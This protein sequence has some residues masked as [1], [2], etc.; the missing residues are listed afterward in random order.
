MPNIVDRKEPPIAPLTRPNDHPNIEG[1]D[2]QEHF[3]HEPVPES[4]MTE[5]PEAPPLD[6]ELD[7]AIASVVHSIMLIEDMVTP[8]E[9]ESF[10]D[11]QDR[12]HHLIFAIEQAYASGEVSYDE[13]M[14]NERNGRQ[15]LI[16]FRNGL[17]LNS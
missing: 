7:Q 4:P 3:P 12:A 13:I 14:E 5:V 2:T 17:K 8:T 10:S 16:D 15:L 6:D 11:I 1:M 9:D